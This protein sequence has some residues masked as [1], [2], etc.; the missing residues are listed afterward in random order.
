MEAKPVERLERRPRTRIEEVST[1]RARWSSWSASFVLH[2]VILFLLAWF[3]TPVMRGTGGERDRPIGIAIVHQN[4]GSTEYFLDAG[5]A[6]DEASQAPDASQ[7]AAALAA[8]AASSQAV[9]PKLNDLL[10]EFADVSAGSL[11][12][13]AGVGTGSLGLSG[14]GDSGVGKG[15][16]KGAKTKTSV[17]G[18]EGAGNS[19]VYVFDRSESMNGYY[20][21]PLRM[22]KKQMSESIASLTSVNQFQIVFYNDSP[23]PYRGSLSR[24]RGLIFATDTEKQSALTYIK[25][26]EGSGGTEHLPALKTALNLSPEVVFFLTDAADPSLSA[27]QIAELADRCL[28]RGTTIHSVE[29]G[30]GPS[31]GEARWIERLAKQ[32]GGQYRY[33]DVT[34][35]DR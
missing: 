5:G 34:Q 9:A 35:L 7:P 24:T 27:S 15:S 31:P 4:Q 1:V 14:T 29:F 2:A 28:G 20:S 11:S 30:S 19:F 12:K 22:A 18:L 33:V 13:A 21:A 23:S 10:G 17:F 3:W 8:M 26:V 6:G 32:T 16:S 25:G